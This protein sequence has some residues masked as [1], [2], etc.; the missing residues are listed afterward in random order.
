MILK[1]KHHFFLY[2]FFKKYAFWKVKKNFQEV[3]IN[4]DVY[5]KGLPVLAISNHVS[6]W[7]GFWVEFVNL[8]I[9]KKKFFFM[10]LEKQLR[11]YWFFNYVGGY[12]VTTNSR[13]ILESLDYSRYLLGD[14]KNFVL[15]FPQGKIHS[16]YEQSVVFQK[17]IE[18]ITEG[19]E[20]KI[21][22]IFVVNLIDYFSKPKPTL[23]VFME[24]FESDSFSFDNIQ[25]G[26]TDFFNRCIE[27]Q[28]QNPS[29]Q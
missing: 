23:F 27:Y 9:F 15:L 25:N 16:I 19:L 28:K 17:G 24:N 8:K 14:N 21:Q 12:S 22:I 4:A 7:D 13:S 2:P 1:A 3:K 20:D 6:W 29:N 18:R 11:K 26:Y 5:D 10:M